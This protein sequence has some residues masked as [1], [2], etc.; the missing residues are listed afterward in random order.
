M[1]YKFK[2]TDHNEYT[3]DIEGKYEQT[4]EADTMFHALAVWDTIHG[5][6]NRPYEGIIR[7]ITY[8]APDQ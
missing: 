1:E 2:W 5:P 6:V 3:F 8:I 4:I 7:S